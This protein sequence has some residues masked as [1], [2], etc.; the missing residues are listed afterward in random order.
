M[1]MKEG[2]ESITSSSLASTVQLN[3][4]NLFEKQQRALAAR[5]STSARVR[6]YTAAGTQIGIAGVGEGENRL[7]FP[8]HFL[9]GDAL[10][11]GRHYKWLRFANEVLD[12]QYASN[13]AKT[14]SVTLASTRMEPPRKKS[15]TVVGRIRSPAP[16]SGALQWIDR[17]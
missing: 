16:M 12:E 7:S 13:S 14:G 9:V 8:R 4:A 11:K 3:A 6:V 5:R 15:T 2:A 1:D 10:N 17:G